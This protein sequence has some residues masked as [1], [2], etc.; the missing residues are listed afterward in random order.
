MIQVQFNILDERTIEQLYCRV[1]H[2]HRIIF[3]IFLNPI[4]MQRE[5]TQVLWNE[6]EDNTI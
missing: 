6:D 1:F 4:I 5:T 3:Y 2:I